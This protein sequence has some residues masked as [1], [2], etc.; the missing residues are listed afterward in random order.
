MRSYRE[1]P[2]EVFVPM[3]A[4]S[5]ETKFGCHRRMW[6][7]ARIDRDG[8]LHVDVE[9]LTDPGSR[10]RGGA[11]IGIVGCDGTYMWSSKAP[12]Y[13]LSGNPNAASKGLELKR[14]W[15]K[16][17]PQYLLAHTEGLIIINTTEPR[18]VLRDLL[19]NKDDAVYIED[20]LYDVGAEF[21]EREEDAFASDFGR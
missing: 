3:S 9:L 8:L 20:L 16:R 12:S 6:T 19:K 2:L 4:E 5:R 1:A 11:V 21:F 17:I 18:A 13:T 15:D 14:H 10:F 7:S